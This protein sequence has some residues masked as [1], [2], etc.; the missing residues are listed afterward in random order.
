MNNH[1]DDSYSSLY[2]RY[3]SQCADHYRMSMWLTYQQTYQ[4]RPS[5]TANNGNKSGNSITAFIK[6]K[7]WAQLKSLDIYIH[8]IVQL[9]ELWIIKTCPLQTVTYKEQERLNYCTQL[10]AWKS[11]LLRK[12]KLQPWLHWPATTDKWEHHFNSARHSSTVQGI[13]Q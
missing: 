2:T 12:H 3:D 13:C 8:R 10:V 7:F 5:S 1:N 9:F 11:L 4:N 6:L